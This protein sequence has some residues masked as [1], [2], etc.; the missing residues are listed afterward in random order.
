MEFT[1][2]FVGSNSSYA[3]FIKNYDMGM[4]GVDAIRQSD[5]NSLFPLK[6][7]HP[8]AASTK[9]DITIILSEEQAR[10]TCQFLITNSITVEVPQGFLNKYAYRQV[11][12][13]PSRHEGKTYQVSVEWKVKEKHLIKDWLEIGAPLF[14]NA[15]LYINPPINIY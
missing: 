13:K 5:L 9:Q 3:L 10:D 2:Q 14:W 1:V 6:D 8:Q 11:T 12:R 7:I 4:D 15:D